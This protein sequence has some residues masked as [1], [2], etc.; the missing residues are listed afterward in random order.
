MERLMAWVR[1]NILIPDAR[2]FWIRPAS[3]FLVK[4][5]KDNPEYMK[6]VLEPLVKDFLSQTNLR[7]EDLTEEIMN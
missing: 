5:L 6:E 4:Y 7:K 1:G 2:M 3:N